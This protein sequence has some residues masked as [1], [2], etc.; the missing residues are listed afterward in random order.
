MCPGIDSTGSPHWTDHGKAWQGK[1]W[2]GMAQHGMGFGE[3]G[4]CDKPIL[5]FE[6]AVLAK[7]LEIEIPRI[8]HG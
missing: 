5:G 7:H 4:L 1:A 2:H 3:W 8:D 6:N